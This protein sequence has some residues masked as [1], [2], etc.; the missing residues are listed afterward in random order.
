MHCQL[1]YNHYLHVI[2]KGSSTVALPS[3]LSGKHTVPQ[4]HARLH[5]CAV[6]LFV[7]WIAWAAWY[8]T[9]LLV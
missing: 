1:E 4:E 5:M 3:M 7:N 2:I 8:N 9:W 6:C